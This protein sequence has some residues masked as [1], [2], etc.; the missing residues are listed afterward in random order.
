M[1]YICL[2]FTF[3]IVGCT[4][5]NKNLSFALQQADKNRPELEKVLNHYKNDSLKYKATV[6]LIKNMPYYSYEVSPQIDSTKHLLSDIFNKWNITDEQQ[7]RGRELQ[8]NNYSTIKYDT[9]EISAKLLIE[10]ID[11]AFEVWKK[12]WN[13]NLPFDDF[14]E[15]ILPYRIGNEPLTQWRKKYYEKYNPILDSLYKGSDAVEACNILSNYMKSEKFYY[16]TDFGT[17]RQGA[18]FQFSNRIGSCQDACDIATYVM[19]SVGI[20]ITT[21]FYPYSPEYKL[22]HQWNVVRDNQGKYRPF[23][24]YLFEAEKNDNFTDKRKK[25]K[26]FRM[27]YGKQN[28]INNS[29]PYVFSNPFSKDVTSEYFGKNQTEIETSSKDIKDVLLGVFTARNGWFVVDKGEVK[30][31]KLIF[32]NIEPFVFYQP[33]TIENEEL[34]SLGYPFMYKKTYTEIFTPSNDYQKITLTRKY[35]LRER[36]KMFKQWLI[37]AK[38]FGYNTSSS[39]KEKLYTITELPK[40]LALKL[41]IKSKKKYNLFEYK[42][43]ENAILTLAEIHFF[44]ASNQEIKFKNIYSDKEPWK[45]VSTY[46]LKNIQD[47]NPLTYFH[48]KDDTN[49]SIFFKS[50]YPEQLK[51]ITIIPRNDDNFIRVGDTYELFYNNGSQGWV[52]LGE[53][54]AT[55][56]FLEYS[57]PKN[58]VLWLK[59]KTRGIEE[60][61]FTYENDRQIFPTF[62][63]YGK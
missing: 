17:D 56:E 3:F 31:N 20:P 62:D 49:G 28:E 8:K 24:Y 41:D 1:K 12:P 30:N 52:S 43:P 46:Q 44:N 63:E 7:K 18:D 21:D 32:K 33:L 37:G 34:V 15:L 26:V 61:I 39:K 22:G 11:L 2:I 40:S 27:C 13:K 59:N 14:C 25:G 29:V 42:S 10:N 38:I 48:T 35:P 6:F 36:T 16:F 4:P 57:A 51:Y 54:T 58:V 45:E 53:Q 5:K 47:N 50:F 60:Q 23:W 55:E 19:R 9:Q